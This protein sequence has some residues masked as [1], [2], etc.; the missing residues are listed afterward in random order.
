MKNFFDW[1]KEIKPV[2][3]WLICGKGPTFA[4]R[5]EVDLRQYNVVTLNHAVREV[6]TQLA[7][8][9]DVEVIGQLRPEA[10][11]RAE[12]FVLPLHPH[13]KYNATK[14]ALPGFFDEYPM[15]RKL[16]EEK[17]LLCYHCSTWPYELPRKE[18]VVTVKHF[19]AEAVIRMLAMA[20]AKTIRTLGVDGGNKYSSDF[21]DI[22]PLTGGHSAFDLQWPEIRRTVGEFQLDFSKIF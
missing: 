4:R 5:N 11:D 15:L 12:F 16:D 13:V 9:I 17:R 19:S 14:K 7:H 8:M 20:G 21:S 2:K 3:P 18:L 10:F 22:K 1:Y 6:D